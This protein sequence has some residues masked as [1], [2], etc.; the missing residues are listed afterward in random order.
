MTRSIVLPAFW[1][2]GV[3]AI[4]S[5]GFAT[6]QYLLYVRGV[7][8]PHPY[9]FDG[10]LLFIAVATVECAVVW[11]LLRPRSY[12]RSWARA[13]FA[14][15]LAVAAVLFFAMGLMHSPLYMF[16]HAL[17]LTLGALA[18]IALTLWSGVA[19]LRMSNA[20]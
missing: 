10:V 17:W 2:I 12:S 20:S 16:V 9:P 18:L 6:D 8:E 5:S 11:A 15:I 14:A 3:I 4:A 19:A 13:L 1:S 7:P